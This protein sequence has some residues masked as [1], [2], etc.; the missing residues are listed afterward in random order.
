MYNVY[1]ENA[2]R[3]HS[4]QLSYLEF[5]LTISIAELSLRHGASLECNDGKCNRY[6]KRV[7]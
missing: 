4:L 1:I 7:D 3:E 5:L 2:R 6:T